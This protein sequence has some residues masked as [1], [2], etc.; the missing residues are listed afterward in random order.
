MISRAS[1]SPVT[2]VSVLTPA[3]TATTTWVGTGP[4][5]CGSFS[6][7]SSRILARR[8]SWAGCAPVR[9][10]VLSSCPSTGLSATGRDFV[11]AI[12]TLAPGGR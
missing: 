2:T 6:S 1:T 8:T 11:L 12:T 3:R 9:I 5:R 10:N 4:S 7:S